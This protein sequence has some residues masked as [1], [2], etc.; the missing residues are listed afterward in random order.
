M[1]YKNIAGRLFGLVT[2]HA[3]DG[4]TD[5]QN[6]DSQDRASIARAVKTVRFILSD[7]CLSC[8]SV[9]F[10]TLVNCGQTVGWIRMP[11]T[12][13]ME[14]GL[15]PDHIVLDEDPASPHGKRHSGPTFRPM[16][17]VAKR[18]PISPTTELLL[19]LF[20]ASVIRFH[21]RC[22]LFACVARPCDC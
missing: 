5:G 20:Y 6:Y 7:R 13:G 9:L 18:S 22:V 3:C 1:W 10:V 14:V 19:Q 4:R 8:L 15:G 21:V 16:S 2:K 12:H 17:T 11:V